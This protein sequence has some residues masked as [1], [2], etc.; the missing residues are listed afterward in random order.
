[1][2]VGKKYREIIISPFMQKLTKPTTYF[3]KRNEGRRARKGYCGDVIAKCL[4]RRKIIIEVY[5]SVVA[6]NS[7]RM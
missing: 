7:C 4:Q 6:S 2:T 1:M 3:Y 5:F